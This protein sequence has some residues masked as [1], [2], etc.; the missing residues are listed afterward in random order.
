MKSDLAKQLINRLRELDWHIATVESCTGGALASAITDIPGASDVFRAGFVTYTKEAKLNL[1]NFGQHPK[2]HDSI[3]EHSVY[4]FETALEMAQ[5]G[6]KA[7]S[8]EVS[9]GITGMLTKGH[10][11]NPT[12]RG[13]VVD[14][15]IVV[16]GKSGHRPLRPPMLVRLSVFNATGRRS[17]KSLKAELVQNILDLILKALPPKA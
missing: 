9:V 15:A 10:P 2:L 7:A 1:A 11:D 12:Y 17:R 16:Q 5:A 3:R 8:V 6:R 4:S 14:V 13:C